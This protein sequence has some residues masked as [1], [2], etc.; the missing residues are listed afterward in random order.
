ML[1]SVFFS[2]L[3]IVHSSPGHIYLTNQRRRLESLPSALS[4]GSGVKT[5]CVVCMDK[6]FV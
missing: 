3:Y 6:A 2:A 4:K 1:F 5:P